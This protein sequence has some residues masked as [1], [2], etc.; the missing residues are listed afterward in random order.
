MKKPALII[1][2]L[3]SALFA[4]AQDKKDTAALPKIWT[5]GIK[6]NAGASAI[7]YNFGSGALFTY[8][9]KFQAG[10]NAGIYFNNILNAHENF[11]FE[12]L[13]L[14]MNG[15][16][17]TNQSLTDTLGNQIGSGTTD[18]FIH[19]S[20][21]SI[22][23]YYKY[24][25]SNF[26]IGAGV[27]ISYLIISSDE[28]KYSDTE[29]GQSNSGSFN[30]K[31]LDIIKYDYGPKLMLSYQLSNKISINLDYYYGLQNLII[32]GSSNGISERNQQLSFGVV[33]KLY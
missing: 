3:L 26:S 9:N 1:L 25:I 17:H 16:F 5:I 15:L 24:R 22:P 6:A 13:F 2:I 4:T 30:A 23:L 20:Y 18:D 27:Q 11:C 19:L 28:T 29:Y 8:S 7:D 33:Y 10:Y 21:L 12:I 32:N 14:H 31:N